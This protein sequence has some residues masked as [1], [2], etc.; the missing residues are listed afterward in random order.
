MENPTVFFDTEI[1]GKHAGRMP[2][3]TTPKV[4]E[5][6][7]ALCTGDKGMRKSGKPLH[8]KGTISTE[9]YKYRCFRRDDFETIYFTEELEYENFEKKLNI[10]GLV[11]S[12]C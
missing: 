8:C 6:F 11:I 12:V 4:V 5:N 7:R 2:T 10:Q 9:I 3:D 1:G